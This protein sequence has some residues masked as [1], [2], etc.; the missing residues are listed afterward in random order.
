MPH[1][2]GGGGFGGKEGEG[3]W[4]WGGCFWGGGGGGVGGGV[5]WG[6]DYRRGGG[7]RGLG[8]RGGLLG[9]GVIFYFFLL[10]GGVLVEYVSGVCGGGG[11]CLGRFLGWEVGGEGV[12]IYFGG[13]FS[14]GCWG[15]GS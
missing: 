11:R 2:G 13:S 8:Q 14:S 6:G 12:C 3:R 15:G 4:E 5:G 1:G 9:V 10:I 7:G